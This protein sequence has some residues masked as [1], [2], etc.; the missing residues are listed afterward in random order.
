MIIELKR[1][2]QQSLRTFYFAN[3]EFIINKT[4]A[5]LKQVFA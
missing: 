1:E 2:V 5:R 3:L 4:V